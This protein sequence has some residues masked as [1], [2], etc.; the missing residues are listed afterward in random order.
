MILILILLCL[1]CACLFYRRRE[2]FEVI[3]Q[4]FF[5]IWINDENEV[6]PPIQQ[7]FE[8]IKEENPD[9]ECQL[10]N[11]IDCI[12][13]LKTHFD[14]DVQK[15]YKSLI[16]GAYKAD[17]MRYCILY[18]KGGIYLD[19]KMKPINN[20][21]L[22]EVVDK[23]Y[24]TRD[25]EGS[26]GGVFNAFIVCNKENPKLL[27]AI[28]EIVKNVDE[29]YYGTSSLEPTGPM[30]LKKVFTQEEIQGFDFEYTKNPVSNNL[31]ISRESNNSEVAILEKDNH[32]WEEQKKNS[33][34]KYYGD[35]WEEH[36]IYRYENFQNYT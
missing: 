4:Y 19:A 13:F 35:L 25:F 20:F 10:Y 12:N 18:K 6:P 11:N 26:G 23:E 24:F 36:N 17:L 5:Q 8:N 31:I 15:A 21:K 30:L 9:F 27:V 16:P 1:L 14:D 28:N 3:P 32:L 7:N 2:G 29:K 33:S 34:E 22:K